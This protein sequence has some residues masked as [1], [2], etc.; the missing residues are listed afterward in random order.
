M[1]SKENKTSAE[2]IGLR[3]GFFIG[4]F[5]FS[6]LVYFVAVKF[7]ILPSSLPYI[8][9]I[10]TIVILHVAYSSLKEVSK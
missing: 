3:I 10:T 5:I 2:K 9:F 4:L 7:R 6:S 1:L 8:Y